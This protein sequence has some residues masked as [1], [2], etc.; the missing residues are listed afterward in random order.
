G[1]GRMVQLAKPTS[2]S[3]SPNSLRG[4]CLLIRSSFLD[5]RHRLT[6]L[7]K[8]RGV[9][10]IRASIS[11]LTVSG[12]Y[13]ELCGARDKRTG[14][15]VFV[16]LAFIS[17]PQRTALCVKIGGLVILWSQS[18][19]NAFCNLDSH[20]EFGFQTGIELQRHFK[21]FLCFRFST[22]NE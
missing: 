7:S 14:R 21:I 13:L 9:S 4:V 12:C 6:V 2:V 20:L 5:R 10:F 16:A 19:S 11:L 15:A 3:V 8:F 22:L 1:I 18:C 17:S